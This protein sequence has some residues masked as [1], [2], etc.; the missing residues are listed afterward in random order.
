MVQV[1]FKQRVKC[2]KTLQTKDLVICTKAGNKSINLQAVNNVVFYDYS[3]ACGDVIQ[4]VGRVARV[5]SVYEYQ[6]VIFLEAKDTIDSYKRLLMQS[7]MTVIQE[8][9]GKSSTMPYYGDIDDDVIRKFRQ[10]F[11]NKLLWKRK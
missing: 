11:K 4:M 7:N 10:Y 2:E 6:N 1:D 9:F 5:D 8:V 3:F